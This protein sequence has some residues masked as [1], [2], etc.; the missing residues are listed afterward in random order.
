MAK[1]AAD[2]WAQTT[3]TFLVLEFEQDRGRNPAVVAVISIP[4]NSGT[5]TKRW[6][7]VQ[8]RLD[9]N[10]VDDVCSWA[11]LTVHNA[12]ISWTGSQGVLPME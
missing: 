3:S 5:F 1:Q 2:P 4:G 12:L 9:A 11:A 10:Q 7:T 8:G 6:K